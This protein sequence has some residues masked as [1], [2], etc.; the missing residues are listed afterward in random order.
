LDHS[1]QLDIG[2]ATL[3]QVA[4]DDGLLRRL[5]L[6]PA[7]PYPV[8]AADLKHAV[9]LVE[10]APQALAKRMKLL[11]S[12]LAGK[13]KM[14]LTAMPAAQAERLKQAAGP[15]VT[16]QLW[17]LPYET[18]A[19]RLRLHPR[20]IIPQ[21][22][23]LLPFYARPGAPLYRGRVLHLKGRFEGDD[24]ATSCYQAARPSNDDISEDFRADISAVQ[25]MPPQVQA[26]AADE[27]NLKAQMSAL[28]K[29]DAS[30]WLGLIAFEQENY[31]SAIDYFTK[32]TLDVAANGPWQVAATY[33]VARAY[34]ASGQRQKAIAWYG[35][36]NT[37]SPTLYG[38]LLR[39]RW[40]EGKGEGKAEGKKSPGRQPGDGPRLKQEGGNR[41]KSPP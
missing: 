20:G 11:E 2:S 36:S 33:N 29:H 34:E 35:R 28:G 3:A 27:A 6:S 12:H 19:C 15:L 26:N 8:K 24:G 17:T 7:S 30:Y 21:L 41:S 4:A 14:V 40:L 5:D 18:L 39:A 22:L 32:R 31:P 16:A 23:A 10:G 25:K 9:L 37:V 1:G 13:Q 38:S